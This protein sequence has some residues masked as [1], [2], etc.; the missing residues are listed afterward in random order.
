M[1]NE[2]KDQTATLSIQGTESAAKTASVPTNPNSNM[3]TNPLPLQASSIVRRTGGRSKASSTEEGT[4]ENEK[5][6]KNHRG[7]PGDRNPPRRR[8][9]YQRT[10]TR[11]EK[12][13]QSPRL[14]R[15]PR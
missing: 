6:T 11:H 8:N 14:P 13:T 7:C 1:T 2:A 9:L 5:S 12:R 10:Q 15:L 4:R 3:K